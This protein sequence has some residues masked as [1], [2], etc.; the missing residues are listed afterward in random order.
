MSVIVADLGTVVEVLKI[1]CLVL[2]CLLLAK[3]VANVFKESTDSARPIRAGLREEDSDELLFYNSGSCVYHYSGCQ[4]VTSKSKT[5]R[6]CSHCAAK[7]A[8]K[9]KQ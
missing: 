8:K 5:L 3:V 1:A 6:L 7:T 9:H 4:D 2:T